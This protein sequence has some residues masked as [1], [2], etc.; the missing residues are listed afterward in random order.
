M[1]NRYFDTLRFF[2]YRRLLR[3]TLIQHE[4]WFAAR[5]LARLMGIHFGDKVQ[6]RLDPDQWRL[7]LIAAG[8]GTVGEEMMVS[9]SG[10]YALLQRHFPHPENRNLRQWLT[11]EVIPALRQARAIA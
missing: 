2:R 8:D 1:T 5:D 10:A 6:A 9:E 4:P 7:G 11:Q 3:A